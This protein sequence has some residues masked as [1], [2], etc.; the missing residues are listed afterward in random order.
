MLS[1]CVV[2]RCVVVLHRFTFMSYREGDERV[3]HVASALS[4]IGVC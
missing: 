4:H 1:F 2:L 3:G